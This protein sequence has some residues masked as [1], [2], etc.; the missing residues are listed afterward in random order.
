MV[1]FQSKKPPPNPQWIALLMPLQTEVWI[2]LGIAVCFVNILQ[3]L[4]LRFRY[5]QAWKFSI[6]IEIHIFS[7]IFQAYVHNII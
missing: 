1:K 3:L 2:T 5:N 7:R 6:I 4:S